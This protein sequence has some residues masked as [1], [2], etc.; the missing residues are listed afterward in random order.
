MAASVQMVIEEIVVL[1]AKHAKKRYPSV[2]N[3]VMAGGVALNCVAN[4]KLYREKIF[5]NIWVQ[6][7]AGDAGGALGSAL[8]AAHTY[9]KIPRTVSEN[10]SQ[11]GS[12]LGPSFSSEEIS[13]CLRK[14]GAVFV[15]Y[16]FL[17]IGCNNSHTFCAIIPFPLSF[18]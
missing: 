9:F 17:N 15:F 13:E 8:Y 3:L 14:Q 16:D 10:D 11:K 1:M 18:T 2:N 4:G 5:D 12:Y 7:A 6:P